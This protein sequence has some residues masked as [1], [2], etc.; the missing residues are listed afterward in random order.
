MGRYAN[1]RYYS[2]GAYFFA[3]LAAAEF[4]FRLA[5]A[6]RARGEARRYPGE[7]RAFGSAWEPRK[8]PVGE[9]RGGNARH[10]ARRCVHADG[11]G[12][13]H[14][15]VASFRSNLTAPPARETSARHL[16]WSYAA[17]IT[18]AAS[19]AQACRATPGSVPCNAA[20]RHGLRS[21]APKC[22]RTPSAWP[23]R[24]HSC[25]GRARS[26]RCASHRRPRSSPP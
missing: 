15:P 26:N 1:D 20:G 12:L 5:Q 22:R 17:F 16:S 24:A 25:R 7:P 4:Y 13:T 6:L 14:P 2:G 18:A 21:R 8:P 9:R 3:T 11:A 19:R 10:A 23:N